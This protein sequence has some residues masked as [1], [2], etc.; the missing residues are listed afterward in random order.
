MILKNIFLDDPLSIYRIREKSDQEF[1]TATITG[2]IEAFRLV[3]HPPRIHR[4]V[5]IFVVKNDDGSDKLWNSQ[6]VLRFD[7]TTTS[8]MTSRDVVMK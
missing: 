4:G 6:S 1:F 5:L 3:I 8:R 2:S 7:F